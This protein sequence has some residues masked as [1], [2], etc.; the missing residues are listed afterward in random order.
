[1]DRNAINHTNLPLHA[2]NK[3]YFFL[4]ERKMAT[5]VIIKWYIRTVAK[6]V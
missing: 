2:E 6:L 4:S 5:A 1:M 3:I